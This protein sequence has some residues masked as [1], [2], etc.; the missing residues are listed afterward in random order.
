[1]TDSVEACATELMALFRGI[2]KLALVPIPPGVPSLERP[3]LMLLFGLVEHQ[4]IRPSLLADHLHLDLSTVSRQLAA[5]EAQGWVS[6]E[7]DPDD[8]RAF[9][10]RISGEG[11]RILRANMA[12]RRQ[13]LGELLTDWTEDDRRDLA[14]L[15]GQLNSI[16]Q[17]YDTQSTCKEPS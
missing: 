4:P 12:A 15:L 16:F 14:R 11:E 2:K 1:M 6:R 9:L 13:L 10:V 5:L 7:R 3:A 17:K 8:R